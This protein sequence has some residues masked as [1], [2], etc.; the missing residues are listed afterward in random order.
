MDNQIIYHQGLQIKEL[1]G[2]INKLEIQLQQTHL[3]HM[4]QIEEYKDII[5]NQRYEIDRL[6]K[7]IVDLG[8]YY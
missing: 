7:I 8:G 3:G 2:Y 5:N 4:N 6:R 1:Q